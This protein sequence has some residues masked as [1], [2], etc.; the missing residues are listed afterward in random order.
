MSQ[1]N[2]GKYHFQYK[3]IFYDQEHICWFTNFATII[4]QLNFWLW[5]KTAYITMKRGRRLFKKWGS[6]CHNHNLNNSRNNTKCSTII[7]LNCHYFL[8][9]SHST[10]MRL[11][12]LGKFLQLSWQKLGSWITLTVQLVTLQVLGHWPKN[13]SPMGKVSTIWWICLKSPDCSNSLCLL[14]T[15]WGLLCLRIIPHDTCS[16]LCLLIA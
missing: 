9:Q 11:S 14:Y 3:Y 8:T 6:R 12:H 4:S 1:K 16:C 15:L 13:N 10:T 5:N 2:W 7:S